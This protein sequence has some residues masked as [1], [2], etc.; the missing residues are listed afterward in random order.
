MQWGRNEQPQSG[1]LDTALPSRSDPALLPYPLS[2]QLPQVRAWLHRLLQTPPAGPSGPPG[3]LGISTGCLWTWGTEDSWSQWGHRGAGRRKMGWEGGG[4][5]DAHKGTWRASKNGASAALSE[6]R[7]AAMAGKRMCP[8][9]RPWEGQGRPGPVPSPTATAGQQL[10]AS[11][12]SP[13]PPHPLL[14]VL[15]GLVGILF[16]MVN[17]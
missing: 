14:R 6:G 9:A 13:L 5:G 11:D 7:G 17:I 1:D 16:Q 3:L 8:W 10:C 4:G 15:L 12:R 2:T